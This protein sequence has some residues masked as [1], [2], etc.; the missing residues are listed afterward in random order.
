MIVGIPNITYTLYMENTKKQRE[1]EAKF[2]KKKQN[3]LTSN[4]CIAECI[5]MSKNM[6]YQI[7]C[8]EVYYNK[9]IKQMYEMYNMSLRHSAINEP[10]GFLINQ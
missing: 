7:K 8:Y 6:A 2:Q 9:N 3:M 5:E 4:V 10:I 1:K